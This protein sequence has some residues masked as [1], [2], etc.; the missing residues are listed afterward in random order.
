MDT[1]D[2]PVVDILAPNMIGQPGG[3]PTTTCPACQTLTSDKLSKDIADFCLILSMSLIAAKQTFFCEKFPDAETGEM[4][5]WKRKQYGHKDNFKKISIEANCIYY[6]TEL[7]HR[8]Y[9]FVDHRLATG[10]HKDPP[11]E[12][13]NCFKCVSWAIAISIE[14]Q[15]P[16]YLLEEKIEG[17]FVKYISNNS[18][19]PSLPLKTQQDIEITHFICFSEHVQFI[20]TGGIMFVSDLQG[21]LSWLSYI[22]WLRL[23]PF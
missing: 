22:H 13:I 20:E 1:M 9:E 23:L 2:N 4:V 6:I 17:K 15:S 11:P 14:Q 3:F 5:N 16:N 7:K 19:E 12:C 18:A 21:M 8:S 10:K